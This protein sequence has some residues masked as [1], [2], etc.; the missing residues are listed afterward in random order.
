MFYSFKAEF[1]IIIKCYL[2][3]VEV[4]IILKVR[5]FSGSI[6]MFYICTA[7]FNI[8]EITQ[9]NNILHSSP[10]QKLRLVAIKNLEA[11]VIQPWP[12]PS[13]MLYFSC[14]TDFKTIIHRSGGK[15]P[16]LSPTLR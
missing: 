13:R 8:L 4:N 3:S 1:P 9:R 14:N 10:S 16:P 12:K 6:Y 5:D 11:E 7:L 15:Y 2:G